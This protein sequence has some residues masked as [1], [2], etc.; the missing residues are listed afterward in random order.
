[1]EVTQETEYFELEFTQA[2]KQNSWKQCK[3]HKK[4]RTFS[5]RMVENLKVYLFGQ[6]YNH[7]RRGSN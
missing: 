7:E 4:N 5:K 6:S 2:S 1:M 3:Q